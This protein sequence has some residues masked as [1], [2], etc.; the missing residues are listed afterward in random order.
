MTLST[1]SR[2]QVFQQEGG[3]FLVLLVITHADIDPPIRV[4]NNT[5]DIV[6]TADG[7]GAQTYIAFPFDVVLPEQQQDAPG[8]AQ[9]T[10]DNVDREIGRTLRLIVERANVDIYVVAIDD[11]DSVEE[12]ITG[13]Y[14]TDINIDSAKVHGKLAAE[15]LTR[16]PYPNY[17]FSPAEYP[18][19]LR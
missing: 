18:G 7:T 17:T 1:A 9:L 11:F 15:D 10:I 14:L 8:E 13:L 3:G 16:E 19:L 12:Q 2:E 5:E 6:S 4:V